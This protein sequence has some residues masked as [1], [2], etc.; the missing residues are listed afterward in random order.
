MIPFFWWLFGR[1]GGGMNIAAM[2]SSGSTAGE[3]VGLLLV[4]TKAS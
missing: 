2:A 3:P 4:L 1:G